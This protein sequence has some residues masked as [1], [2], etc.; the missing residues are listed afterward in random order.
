[1]QIARKISITST[2]NEQADRLN[3]KLFKRANDPFIG[4]KPYVMRR[5]GRSRS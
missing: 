1:L 5:A 2:E 3:T 4:A